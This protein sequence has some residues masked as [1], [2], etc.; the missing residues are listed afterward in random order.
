MC[1]GKTFPLWE[2]EAIRNVLAVP[3]VELAVLIV[4]MNNKPVD[5]SVKT[6]SDVKIRE[7]LAKAYREGTTLT[8]TV[9][10]IRECINHFI[11]FRGESLWPIYR[12]MSLRRG[13]PCMSP[14]DLSKELQGVPEVCCQREQRERFSQYFSSRDVRPI[15][16][17][18]LDLV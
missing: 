10:R 11:L 6:A 14:V 16:S 3:G 13:M 1:R 12:S 5:P 4:D 7:R 9:G 8:K 2:A 18:E 17:L 15:R